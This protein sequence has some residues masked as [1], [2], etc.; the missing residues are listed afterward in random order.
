MGLWRSRSPETGVLVQEDKLYVMWTRICDAPETILHS[1]ID[2]SNYWRDWFGTE[3]EE[4]LRPKFEWVGAHLPT[5]TSKVGDI[6]KH[7]HALRDP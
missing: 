1:T 2:L 4:I 7:E 6:T 5:S 3:G